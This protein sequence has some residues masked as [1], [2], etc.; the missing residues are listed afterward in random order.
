VSHQHDTKNLKT[1]FFLNLFFTIIEIVGGLYTNSIA[2]LSDAIHDL[3]DSISLGISVFLEKLSK[4]D[5]DDK[6]TYGYQRF[7][8]LG[9]LITSMVLFGGTIYILTESIPRLLNPEAVDPAGMLVFAILGIVFNGLAFYRI[10]RGE[11]KSMN[12]KAVALHLLEDLFGWLAILIGSIILLFVDF[13]ILDALMSI[14]IAL[15]ILFHVYRNLK[16]IFAILLQKSPSNIDMRTIEEHISTFD[17]VIKMYHTHVWSMD[18]EK[19][20]CSTHLVLKRDLTIERIQSIKNKVR[21]YLIENSIE[22]VTIECEFLKHS[23]E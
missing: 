16:E 14:G 8:L 21:N 1:A 4:K 22:H 7:S 20:M 12:E 3:G 23:H 10:H 15:F 5:P 17:G 13:F 2:I 9:A 11:Q 6:Y 19:V 18:G